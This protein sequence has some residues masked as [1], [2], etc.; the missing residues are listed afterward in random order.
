M[1]W[2]T[3]PT[4]PC[5][6]READRPPPP[7][8]PPH[9]VVRREAAAQARVSAFRRSK[10]SGCAVRLPR[11]APARRWSRREATR[12]RC[13]PSAARAL[14]KLEPEVAAAPGAAGG[15]GGGG[16]ARGGAREEVLAMESILGPS[17]RGW[18]RASPITPPGTR[19]R[20]RRRPRRRWPPTAVAAARR[21]PRPRCPLCAARLPAP[22][23]RHVESAYCCKTHADQTTTAIVAA[24]GYKRDGAL[25]HTATDRLLGGVSGG[26][27]PEA[28]A[29]SSS[30]CATRRSP[31]AGRT[32]ARRLSLRCAAAPKG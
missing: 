20:E 32:R 16:G 5:A 21:P 26:A 17:A 9:I 3:P 24:A 7:P 28:L 12:R 27:S 25:E 14:H 4:P 8:P 29:R 2:R 31:A 10:R 15:R 19:T 13:W 22:T 18:A 1:R 23:S 11:L 30:S 6:R